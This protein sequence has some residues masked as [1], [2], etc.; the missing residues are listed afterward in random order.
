MRKIILCFAGTL[1]VLSL[2]ACT[3]TPEKQS[4]TVQAPSVEATTGG[5][6]D[7][8]PDPNVEPMEVIA[9]Y[10]PNEEGNALNQAMDAVNELTP[11]AL[12]DKLIEYG[13]L[14]EGTEVL[15]YEESEG[16]ASLDLSQ[17]PEG[18]GDMADLLKD[19][20]SSTFIQNFELDEVTILV[21]GEAA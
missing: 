21:N 19:A 6:Q 7:K 5:A 13:V 3:P 14:D 20:V 1:M 16:T 9:I 4:E 10:S 2:A 15:S 11:L 8:V 18:S 17:M 12:V